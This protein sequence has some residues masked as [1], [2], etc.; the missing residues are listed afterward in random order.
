[1]IGLIKTVYLKEAMEIAFELIEIS[2]TSRALSRI[3]CIRCLFGGTE[4]VGNAL[5]W[6]RLSL[7]F[8][9]LNQKGIS[10]RAPLL[11]LSTLKELL[12]PQPTLAHSI[13]HLKVF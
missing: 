12:D 13:E 8:A 11:W 2:Q 9:W 5:D 3:Q 6:W 1:M 7:F 10:T 4:P